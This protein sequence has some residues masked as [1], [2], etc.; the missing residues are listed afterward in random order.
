MDRTGRYGWAGHARSDSTIDPGTIGPDTASPGTMG[1]SY[2]GAI[3]G[4]GPR[5]SRPAGVRWRSAVAGAG[6][7]AAVA[8]LLTAAP[9]YAGVPAAGVAAAAPAAAGL[10]SA[11]V[12]RSTA[13]P[14][15]AATAS[16]TA[17][18]TA[19]PT[20]PVSPAGRKVVKAVAVVTPGAG[21]VVG[22]G[23]L[24][25]VKFSRPV[26]DKRA[27][28]AALS[29][30]STQPL[31]PGSW[32]W[33]APDRVVYRPSTWWPGHA[34]LTVSLRLSGVVLGTVGRG[35]RAKDVMVV[36]RPDRDVT[37]QTGRSL[38]ATIQNKTHRMKV[39]VD[40]RLVRTVGVSL[41]K[42][43]FLTRSGIKILS[44]EKYVVKR[45]RNTELDYDV[46][47]P[48]SVRLTPSGEYIHGAPWA[49]GRIGR[50]N[51]SHGCTNLRVTDAKWFYDIVL[52]GDVVVTVGTGRR[53]EP[54]NGPGAP[55]NIPWRV[56][57]QKSALS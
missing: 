18:V 50:Y 16:T 12:I 54:T 32:A 20:A 41:G 34:Q 27:V 7:L 25:T 14:A 57:L 26:R 1:T 49:T 42:S 6:G 56:W 33:L 47:A 53:M 40:G 10:V 9:A 48:W 38:V 35:A 21:S 3:G 30:S 29:I 39:V 36:N 43:G 46:Q 24:I 52:P 13:A 2:P 5:L 37:F 51:G 17:P 4:S 28:E 31:P 23:Q 44:G 15:L 11:G 45:M 22:V 8:A 55:W 19:V